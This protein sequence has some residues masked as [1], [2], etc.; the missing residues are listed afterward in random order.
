M[1]D[2][3]Q[4]VFAPCVYLVAKGLILW[5]IMTTV[6]IQMNQSDTKAVCGWRKGGKKGEHERHKTRFLDWLRRDFSDNRLTYKRSTH[7]T[8]FDNQLTIGHFC[9]PFG[10]ASCKLSDHSI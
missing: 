2:L 1:L 7:G 3:E 5:P 10:R 8:T 6:D 4:V 9:F